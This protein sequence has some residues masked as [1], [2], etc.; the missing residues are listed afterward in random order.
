VGWRGETGVVT[1]RWWREVRQ[2]LVMLRITLWLCEQEE[3]VRPSPNGGGESIAVALTSGRG[4]R[5]WRSRILSAGQCSDG[6]GGWKSNGEGGF[7][8]GCFGVRTEG[9]RGGGREPRCGGIGRLPF[10]WRRGEAGE[11]RG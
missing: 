5:R 3:E 7:A 2:R 8:R 4:R 11:G 6:G 9:A 1:F 10:E